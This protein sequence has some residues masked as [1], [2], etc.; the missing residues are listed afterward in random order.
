MELGART[1]GLNTSWNCGIVEFWRMVYHPN[2][3]LAKYFPENPL[4]DYKP[5]PHQS[6]TWKN[7]IYN[8]PLIHQGWWMIGTGLNITLPPSLVP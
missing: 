3:L 4:H 2:T 6:W 7:I 5:N 1:G 8:N